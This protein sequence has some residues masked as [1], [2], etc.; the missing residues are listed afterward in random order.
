MYKFADM[1]LYLVSWRRD[2][3]DIAGR[4]A[5]FVW[6]SDANEFYLFLLDKGYLDI[7]VE[8]LPISPAPH[9][10][11]SSG[12]SDRIEILINKMKLLQ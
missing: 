4:S 3:T 9:P 10:P 11:H 5:A 8:T 6:E 1:N 2:A 12:K 7:R